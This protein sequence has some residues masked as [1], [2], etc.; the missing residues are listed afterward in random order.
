MGTREA[1][2]AGTWYPDTAEACDRM[3]SELRGDE[4]LPTVEPG[5]RGGIVPHA[6]WVFSGRVALRVLETLALSAPETETVLLFAGHLAPT[7]PVS[8]MVEGEV[9]TPY[10]PIATDE[11]LAHA[12]L[13]RCHARAETGETHTQD[14][15][16]EVQFPLLKRLWPAARIVVVGAP[17]RVDSLELAQVAAELAL[18]RGRRILAVGSTDL[19]HYGP[20][21]GFTPRG[22]GAA[23]LSWVRDENDPRFLAQA[24]RLDPQAMI[25]EALSR[26]NACCPGAAAAAVHCAH[27]LGSTRA[28]LLAYATSADVRPD[29]S[30]VGYGGVVF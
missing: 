27:R 21:Y 2:L 14:N 5:L 1:D 7:S 22:R 29:D 26:R 25:V 24:E 17:P 11:E 30:F 9:W 19:T 3:I 16:A 20:N 13:Q 6:G 15:S 18:D 4:P 10:G 12:L 28:T 23:A 8:V